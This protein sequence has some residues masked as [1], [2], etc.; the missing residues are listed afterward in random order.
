LY[1]LAQALGQSLDSL[2]SGKVQEGV[3]GKGLT[4][5]KKK[6]APLSRVQ[7]AGPK[8]VIEVLPLLPEGGQRR[9]VSPY[10]VRLGA[11][12][13]DTRSFFDHKGHEFGWILSGVLKIVVGDQEILL[14]KG[15]SIYVEDQTIRRW[16][17][18]GAGRCELLWVLA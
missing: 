13:E 14:R 3:S 11:G 18:E 15:D 5:H 10:M 12:A 8:P 9:R 17:N 1:L 16:R 7:K 4:V 2:F 6:G